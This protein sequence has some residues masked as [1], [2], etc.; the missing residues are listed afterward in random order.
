MD[1]LYIY[2]MNLKDF[3]FILCGVCLGAAL[4]LCSCAGMRDDAPDGGASNDMADT[5]CDE[6]GKQGDIELEITNEKFYREWNQVAYSRIDS[7]AVVGVFPALSV[8]ALRPE[9]CKMCHSFS[10]DALDFDLAHFEDSLFVA[11][12]P[13]MQ[14]E[15]MLPGMRLPDADS[16]Y[17]DTLSVILLKSKFADGKTLDNMTPWLERDGIEQTLQREVPAK[18]KNALNDIASRY[19]LRYISVPVKLEVEMMPDLGTAGGYTWKILWSFWDARYGEL[20]FLTYSEFTAAT[21]SRVAPEKE[22]AVPFA[23]RLWKMFSV[24]FSKLENH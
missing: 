1:N 20:V 19:G 15:L 11:A 3:R 14:R 4:M 6:C 9:K 23:P 18:F 21:T 2:G 12:F 24:D 5:G 10:P 22:W 17:L 7:S 8:K 13:K 16:L